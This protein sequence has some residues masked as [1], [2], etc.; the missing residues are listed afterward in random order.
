MNKEIKLELMIRSSPQAREVLSGECIGRPDR[1][2]ERA[3]IS[4][5]LT[6]L[7][8][9]ELARFLAWELFQGLKAERF[10]NALLTSDL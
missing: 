7:A 9:I 2:T 4:R 3:A 10:Q 5:L 6:P 8:V 1:H